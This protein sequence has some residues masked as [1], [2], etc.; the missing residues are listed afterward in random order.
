MLR[1]TVALKALSDHSNSS[2]VTAAIAW[3]W[4]WWGSIKAEIVL[5]MDGI[6]VKVREESII[7]H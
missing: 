1:E 3:W 4:W 5:I 7:L 2:K 6:E